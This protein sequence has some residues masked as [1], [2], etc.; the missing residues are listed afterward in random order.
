MKK[1][2][3]NLQTNYSARGKFPKVF[4]DFVIIKEKTNNITFSFERKLLSKHLFVIQLFQIFLGAFIF[5][6]SY[7]K[8][9]VYRIT[10]I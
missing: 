2:R 8:P 6:S 9:K 7:K 10:L 4:F 5:Y 1:K 3:T